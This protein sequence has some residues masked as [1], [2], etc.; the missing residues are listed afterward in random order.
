EGDTGGI[1]GAQ[2]RAEVAGLLHP[3]AEQDEGVRG[4]LDVGERPAG[5]GH[6]AEDAVGALPVGDLLEGGTAELD[7]LGADPTGTLDECGPGGTIEHELR[8]VEDHP[9]HDA[10]VEGE[11]GL[12]Q[13][14][15]ERAPGALPGAAAAQGD[16]VLQALVGRGGDDEIGH[17]RSS[18]PHNRCVPFDRVI[19]VVRVV[20]ALVAMVATMLLVAALGVWVLIPSGWVRSVDEGGV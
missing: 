5:G 20:A 16:Q 7:D 6:S 19:S 18:M 13:T 9:G 17:G 8:A 4:E 3:L 1:G 12:L 2:H 15:E 11:A 10:R 14:L